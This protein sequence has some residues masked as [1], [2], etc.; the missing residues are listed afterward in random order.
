M[1]AVKPDAGGAES[2]SIEAKQEVGKVEGEVTGVKAPGL[3]QATGADISVTQKAGVIEG[4]MTGV[5]LRKT[6]EKR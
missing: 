6:E 5:D 4:S 2:T 1:K 3:P